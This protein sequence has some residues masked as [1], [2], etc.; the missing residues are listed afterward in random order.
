MMTLL[1][2][3]TTWIILGLIAG[4]VDELGLPELIDTVIKQDH[5]Q[6]QVS[7]GLCVKAMILN[8]LAFVNRALYL[9]PHFFKDKPVELLL[10]EGVAAE[11]LNGDALGRA[12][13][14]STLMTRKPCTANWQPK[15]S[16]AWGCPAKS[17]T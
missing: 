1:T 3:V 9:M 16:N 4:M 12:L 10:G 6:R 15:R 17:G 2:A 8:G 14:R 5:E 11:H 13:E 7:V